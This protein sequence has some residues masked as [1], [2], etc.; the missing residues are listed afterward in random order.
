LKNPL[1]N[2]QSPGFPLSNFNFTPIL[3]R[4]PETFTFQREVSDPA[5]KAKGDPMAVEASQSGLS[6]NAASGLAYVTIIPAII[7]LLLEPFNRNPLVRFHAWQS[8]FLAIAWIV[9]DVATLILRLLPF[10]G[11]AMWFAVPLVELAFFVIWLI[12]LINA[13]NGKRIKLPLVGDLAEKQANS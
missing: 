11:W 6:D 10:V 4:A 1:D 2:R 7:F 12:V 3:R 9:V 13:F 8:I 5:L